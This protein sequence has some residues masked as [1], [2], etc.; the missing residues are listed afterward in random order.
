[1]RLILRRSFLTA[2][3]GA[4]AVALATL[5]ALTPPFSAPT[6]VAACPPEAVS[7]DFVPVFLV[8]GCPPGAGFLGAIVAA[9]GQSARANRARAAAAAATSCV[10]ITAANAGSL[11]MSGSTN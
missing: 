10:P 6:P 1:M 4:L 9:T 2:R 11:L 8:D 7:S 3:L 5:M